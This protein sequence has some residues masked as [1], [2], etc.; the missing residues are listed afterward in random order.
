MFEK[1]M[2]VAY[3]LDFYG[4]LLDERTRS[5][6]TSYYEDD[7]SLAEIA[8]GENISRQGVRHVIKKGEDELFWLE[9]KLGLIKQESSISELAEK[10]S[11]LKALIANENNENLL[12]FISDI[13]E[14]IFKILNKGF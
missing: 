6:M 4:D 2:N 3:L 7:L 9:S 12:S 8:N 14:S 10:I 13:E 1:N 11:K 5:I